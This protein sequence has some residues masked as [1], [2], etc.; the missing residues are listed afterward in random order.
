LWEVASYRADLGATANR[1]THTV[2]NLMNRIENTSS[3]RSQIEDTDFASESASLAKSQVLQQAGTA[4]LA[5]ANASG[6][7]V[8]SLLK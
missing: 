3:A 5:Q 1:L 7:S 8:M 2:D 6:Q 4:M